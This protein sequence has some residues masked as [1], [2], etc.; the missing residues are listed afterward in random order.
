M[1]RVNENETRPKD[2]GQSNASEQ[3]DHRPEDPRTDPQPPQK[4]F[5]KRPGPIIFLIV[6]LVGGATVGLIYWLNARHY[7]STDDAFIEGHVIAVS[8][9][10]SGIVQ[11]VYIDDNSR[12]KS[13]DLLVELDDRDYRAALVQAQ[14]D[15][16][17]AEG[18]VQEAKAQVPV[19]QANVGEADAELLVAQANAQN[20]N[21]DLNRFLALDVRARS[22]QQMDNATAAQRTTA[23]QVE[24]AKA[25]VAAA[26]AQLDDA[27]V[28]VQTAQGNL[29]A[30]E[31]ALQQARNNLGYCKIHAESDGVITRKNVE[32]GTYIQV[33]Q[34]MFSIVEY[35]VWVVANFK[36]TQL[37]RIQPGQP[38]EIFVDAYPGRSITGKVQSVQDGTGSAFSLLPPE[39]ATGNYVKIVQRIPVK[40]VF[41]PHQ[42]DDSDH[43]LSPG[44][45]VEPSVRVR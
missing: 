15:D 39:N 8:P 17:S 22:K 23:A 36:E 10:V 41:D 3:N 25:K 2:S 7:E 4:P 35:D 13:G 27:R 12:V 24:D 32:P 16:A 9:K 31:G 38:V 6:L 42:N 14:G 43:L 34:P 40:I 19:A 45:S 18:K 26:K 21:D 28:A 1:T 11:K 44:M 30:A 5:Y 37:D 20:S 33:D 29:K